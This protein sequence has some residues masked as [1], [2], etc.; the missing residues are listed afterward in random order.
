MSPHE[1][2]TDGWKD[3]RGFNIRRWSSKEI[4]GNIKYSETA[5][6]GPDRRFTPG[7]FGSRIGWSANSEE[8]ICC[9]VGYDQDVVEAGGSCILYNWSS[10]TKIIVAY[11]TKNSKQYNSSG[12]FWVCSPMATDRLSGKTHPRSPSFRLTETK[13]QGIWDV[14]GR[15]LT[16]ASMRAGVWTA[17]RDGARRI[18]V[19]DGPSRNGGAL[20][21]N[22]ASGE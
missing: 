15:L 6:W 9:H 7:E 12:D 2:Y 21:Y 18:V 3:H 8:W 20:R 1:Y 22:N 4:V 10:K 5:S 16:G 14:R 17:G 11:N 13:G 19:S